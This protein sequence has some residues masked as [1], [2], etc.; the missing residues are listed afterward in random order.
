MQND[1]DLAIVAME[2]RLKLTSQ[3]KQLLSAQDI[4]QIVLDL[5]AIGSRAGNTQTWFRLATP[6]TL[7]AVL[8][9]LPQL[10]QQ[11][12]DSL[13]WYLLTETPSVKFCTCLEHILVHLDRQ[14]LH[15]HPAS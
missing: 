2:N 9:A 12:A 7:P 14:A 13:L 10:L 3:A 15:G 5:T 6:S 1:H 4:V 11:S 8:A